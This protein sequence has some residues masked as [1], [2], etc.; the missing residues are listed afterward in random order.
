MRIDT[1]AGQLLHETAVSWGWSEEAGI[2]ALAQAANSLAAA[3]AGCMGMEV[4]IMFPPHADHVKIYA[5]ERCIRKT[6]RERGI[7]LKDTKLGQCP[8]YA[9]P[10]VTVSGIGYLPE[11][12]EQTGAR[13]G[14]EIVQVKWAGMEGML[15]ILDERGEELSQRFAPVFIS[16]IRSYRDEIFSAEELETAREMKVTAVRQITDGGILAAL[17]KLAKETGMGIEADMKRISI[18]QETIEVCEHYRLNPYQT[19]S[20]G[21]FLMLTEDGKALADALE[22]KQIRASV[23]GRLTAGNDKLI[24]NGEDIRYIDRPAP[25]EIYKLFMGG[26]NDGRDEKSNIKVFGEEQQS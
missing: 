21:S 5:M 15:R 8:L 16:Q 12:A 17:W 13:A 26:K 10:A 3:G 7:E 25:D 9:A 18:L 1:E 23:I 22:R 2:Y 14:E 6:C 4:Q 11:R 20:A 24:H 19:A